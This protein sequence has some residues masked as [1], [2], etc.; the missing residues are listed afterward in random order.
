MRIISRKNGYAHKTVVAELS[1]EEAKLPPEVLV[2]ML[3]GKHSQEQAQLTFAKGGH[4][5]NFGYRGFQLKKANDKATLS[6][7]IH[8][9]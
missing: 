5:G 7:I 9:D 1:L 8:T 3:D 4:P 6:V 2:M